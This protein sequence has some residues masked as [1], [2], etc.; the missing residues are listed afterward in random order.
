MDAQHKSLTILFADISGSSL[1]YQ[2]LG[3][4]WAKNIVGEVLAGIIEFCHPFS[5]RCFKTIGDEVM[6]GFADASQAAQCA[7]E[8]QQ[9]F[10]NHEHHIQLRIGAAYGE[11]IVEADDAFG[12]VVNDAAYLTNLAA[13][14][15]III[16]HALYQ[17]LPEELKAQAR[18]FDHIALKGSDFKAAV[19]RLYWR[20]RQEAYAETQI[21]TASH[22]QRKIAPF[23]VMLGYQNESIEVFA[24]DLPFS[25]G[26]DSLRNDLCIKQVL[27]SRQH[28]RIDMVNGKLVLIDA[29][30][31][32]TYLQTE[33]GTVLFLR[34]ESYPLIGKGLISL[35]SPI[36]QENEAIVKYSTAQN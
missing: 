28:C 27:V 10:E 7:I 16:D 14:G 12:R 19:Y 30:T 5:G 3:D 31:N 18:I 36:D 1:L 32:G 35:G 15:Q 26:R 25:M 29:S 24:D 34:R 8:L 23:T 21:I 33:Q 6:L 9:K 17:K 20:P 13:A 22:I 4:T 2:D 11:V